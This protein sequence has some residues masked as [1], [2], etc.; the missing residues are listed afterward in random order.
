MALF[1]AATFGTAIL[2]SADLE[3]GLVILQ[4]FDSKT[5]T[6][7]VMCMWVIH[8]IKPGKSVLYFCFWKSTET[9]KQFVMLQFVYYYKAVPH[10]WMEPET[11]GKLGRHK[12]PVQIMSQPF[13]A[14]CAPILCQLGAVQSIADD[15]KIQHTSQ[16]HTHACFLERMHACVNILMVCQSFEVVVAVHDWKLACEFLTCKLHEM[17]KVHRIQTL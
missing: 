14:C 15:I 6:A 9:F 4:G 7:M 16:N 3:S 12:L 11:S 17:H 1:L 2:N 13:P 5:K 10:R 8:T